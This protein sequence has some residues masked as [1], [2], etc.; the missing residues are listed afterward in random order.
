MGYAELLRALEGEVARRSHELT[1]GAERERARLLDEAR[2]NVQ[3]DRALAVA[4]ARVEAAAARDAARARDEMDRERALLVERR[5]VLEALAA[6]ADAELRT[7]ATPELTE[8]L[9]AEVLPEALRES[10]PIVLRVAA[11]HAG[12]VRAA[13]ARDFPAAVAR[14][15]IEALPSGSAG[16]LAEANGLVLDD[17]LRA[18]AARAWRILEP[19][20]VELLFAAETA[21]APAARLRPERE[22]ADGA[23]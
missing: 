21:A 18:R 7:L 16:V 3:K 14:T 20:L 17:T 15:R 6:E 10:G 13:L 9:V 1:E 11:A 23:A 19:R 12:A 5:R 4:C 2:G 8:R 22:V